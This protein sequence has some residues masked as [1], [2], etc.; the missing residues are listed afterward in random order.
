M[1]MENLQMLDNDAFRMDQQLLQELL[2]SVDKQNMPLGIILISPNTLCMKCGGNLTIRGDRY[3]KLALY[4]EA[5]G[6][7]L[8]RHYY[9]YCR[10]GCRFSQHYGYYSVDDRKY[11]YNT[12]WAELPYFVSSQETAF[13]LQMIQKFDVEL[14]IGQVSYKQKAE[15]YNLHHGYEQIAKINSVRSKNKEHKEATPINLLRFVMYIVKTIHV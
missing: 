4:T 15:I 1:Q 11:Y 8:A 2:V 3:S 12:N 9:K 7:V 13:E 14:L 6:T 5:M 10:K